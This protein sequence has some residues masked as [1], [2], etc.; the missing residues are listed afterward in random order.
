MLPITPTANPIGQTMDAKIKNIGSSIS[1]LS[2]ILNKPEIKLCNKTEMKNPAIEKPANIRN[3]LSIP[4][5]LIFLI[6]I[7]K[8]TIA[9]KKNKKRSMMKKGLSIFLSYQKIAP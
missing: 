6:K 3:F 9:N 8:N 2:N 7:I 5:G 1:F 4:C